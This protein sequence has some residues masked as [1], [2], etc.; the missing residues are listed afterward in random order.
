[1]AFLVAQTFLNVRATIE[2][3]T[4]LETKRIRHPVLVADGANFA[5]VPSPRFGAVPAIDPQ[6]FA[7]IMHDSTP[8]NTPSIQTAHILLE[9]ESPMV[10]TVAGWLR[11]LGAKVDTRHGTFASAA[12]RVGQETYDLILAEWMPMETIEQTPGL[13]AVSRM[14]SNAGK[15]PPLDAVLAPPLTASAVALAVARWL[16]AS[17]L[18]NSRSRRGPEKPPYTMRAF[19]EMLGVDA[20]EDRA[21]IIDILQLFLGQSPTRVAAIRAAISTTEAEKLAREAHGLKGSCATL[22]FNA[23]ADC[24]RQLE[25]QAM[26]GVLDESLDTLHRLEKEFARIEAELDAFVE[27]STRRGR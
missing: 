19:A 6:P 17:E 12:A 22:G 25:D 14:P 1:M 23:L 27:E 18:S 8:G 20:V 21:T 2:P 11:E 9:G 13:I 7:G 26:H 15:T 3:K 16:D 10:A 5:G 24:C 4:G